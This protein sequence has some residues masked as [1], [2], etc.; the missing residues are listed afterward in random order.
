MRSIPLMAARRW[1]GCLRHIKATGRNRTVIS[2]TPRHHGPMPCLRRS[3][4][5]VAFPERQVISL[6]GDG[7]LAMLLLGD[8]ITAIQENIAIKVVVVFNN[9]SLGFVELEQKVEGL[10]DSYTGLTNPDFARG[11]AEAIGFTAKR[12]EKAELLESAVIEWLA[13]P[14]PAFLDVVTDRMELVLPAKIEPTQV[15]GLW[16]FTR[17]K[18]CL[19][20]RGDEVVQLLTENFAD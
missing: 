15:L 18:R 14:G 10:L 12:V 3:G 19:S 13:A 4:A 2:L 5:K 17:P 1:S 6:S 7:G 16:R 8:L 11:V 9:S 20:G